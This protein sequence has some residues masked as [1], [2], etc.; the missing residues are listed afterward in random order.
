MRS[1]HGYL[2]GV[3]HS[4]ADATTIPKPSCLIKVFVAVGFLQTGCPFCIRFDRLIAGKELTQYCREIY[5]L[6]D[7]RMIFTARCYASAVLAMGLCLSICV[8]LCLSVSLTD[9]LRET[10]TDTDA[11]TSRCS[12]KTAKCR[13]TQ[14]TP[15]NTPG[16]LVF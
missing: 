1:W 2:S 16:S 8:R 3:R 5:Y 11:V 10:Q 7:C 15:H 12:T 13:I 4:P 14:T 6:A 9:R